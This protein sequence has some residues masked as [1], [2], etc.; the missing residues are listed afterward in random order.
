GQAVEH[1]D[2]RPTAVTRSGDDVSA[3]VAGD[4]A[5]CDRHPAVEADVVG[6][7]APQDGVGGAVEDLDVRPRARAGADDDVGAAIAVDVAGRH[8]DRADE[9]RVES[10]ETL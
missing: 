2:V 7:E 9:G 10:Q 5:G 3:A 8:G 6:V 4:V 1:L